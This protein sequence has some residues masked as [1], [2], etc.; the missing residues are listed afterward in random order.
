MKKTIMS[1]V[2]VTSCAIALMMVVS[3]AACTP[4]PKK[5]NAGNTSAPAQAES[6]SAPEKNPDPTAP[7]LDV[8]SV[9]NVSEDGTKL[10]GTMDAVEELNAES[11][12]DLLI[13]YG[14]LEEGTK[15]VNYEATGEASSVEV[16]PGAAA[17]SSDNEMK[18]YGTL[19]LSQ[20]PDGDNKM[21][22]QAVANT[23]IENMKI[24]YLTIQVNGETVSE[25][26]AMTDAGK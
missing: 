14:V 26:L 23:F 20:F 2:K 13:Q 8:V 7:E 3:L 10:E 17:A 5:E 22:L 19:N 15:V 4:T 1:I 16:G 18:E 12:V 24:V 6:S 25:N 21:V 11:L 9:Y